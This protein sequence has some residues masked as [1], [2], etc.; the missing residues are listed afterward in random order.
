MP[1]SWLGDHL[2]GGAG[3]GREKGDWGVPECWL[4]GGGGSVGW[5][6]GSRS[7]VRIQGQGRR[8]QCRGQS[9]GMG[10]VRAQRFSDGAELKEGEGET[11][12]ERGPGIGRDSIEGVG[13]R[14]R[15]PGEKFPHKW[16]GSDG[17]GPRRGGT[18]SFRSC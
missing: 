16:V 5:T 8:A 15:L 10:L 2:P 1:G 17:A 13:D 3:W 12:S 11:R 18:W 7:A 9:R 4:G 14:A 6:G